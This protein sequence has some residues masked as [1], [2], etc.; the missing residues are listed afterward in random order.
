MKHFGQII[1]MCHK[2][3]CLTLKYDYPIEWI[4]DHV[5][6][7]L[8]L[9]VVEDESQNSKDN[10]FPEF[11]QSKS[12]YLNIVLSGKACT[13]EVMKCL[14]QRAAQWE[15]QPIVY[16][17]LTDV[18]G[19]TGVDLS[20]ILHPAMHELHVICTPGSQ[21]KVTA[22]RDFAPCPFLTH[23]SVTGQA[24]LDKSVMTVL[25][26][27]IKEGKLSSLK[28]LSLACSNLA[29]QM[30]HLSEERI[31]STVTT[32]SFYAMDQNSIEALS[33]KWKNVTNLSIHRLTISGFRTVMKSIG[34]GML[35]NLKKFFLSMIRNKLIK[36][37]LV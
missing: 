33:Q 4:L 8:S 5:R 7:M 30:I 18:T 28:R 37:K 11:L 27:A 1:E 32:M 6:S 3:Q 34:Q 9:I 36:V 35:T 22:N 14:L 20:E 12:N 17:F 16:L 23:L 21:T 29:D 25:G 15:R 2:V 10:V 26:K 13:T 24:T 31:M 19:G